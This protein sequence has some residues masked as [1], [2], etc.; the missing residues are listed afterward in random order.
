[1]GGLIWHV[2]LGPSA[3]TPSPFFADRYGPYHDIN[4]EVGITSTP[5]IDLATNT[6][7]L[8]AFTNDTPGQ[9]AFSHHIWSLDITTGAQK[10]TP[11]LVA[12]TIPS[13]S[14]G[15]VNGTLTFSA[16]QQ[17]QRSA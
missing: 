3:A 14:P 4:P 11:A 1:N 10:A 15:S 5:V 6:I 9:N 8:D 17:L 12:A 13:T 7:Y 16:A 2:N